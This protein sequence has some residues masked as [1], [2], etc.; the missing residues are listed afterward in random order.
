MLDEKTVFPEQCL[1]AR[2]L[3][4]WTRSEL[5]ERSGVAAST[6]ADF[7]AGKR[8]PYPR[9]LADIR[10]TLEEAGVIFIAADAEAGA[11]VRKAAPVSTRPGL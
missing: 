6:L 3:V 1:A 11:G 10:R 2:A 7:E 9:T 4:G 8:V 5:A